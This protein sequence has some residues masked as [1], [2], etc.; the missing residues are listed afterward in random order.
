MIVCIL[1]LGSYWREPND[2]RPVVWNSSGVL[3][4]RGLRQ[5]SKVH[6]HV[7][8]SSR[9]YQEALGSSGLSGS[10]WHVS[11][12]G[13]HLGMR[14]VALERRA[15]HTSSPDWYLVSV[16]EQLVGALDDGSWD[17]ASSHLLSLSSWKTKQEALLLVDRHGWLRGASGSAVLTPGGPDGDWAISR[18]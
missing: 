14:T 9:L 17:P 15:N 8:L 18:W 16:T 4:Q 13:E 12:F 10:C 5:R 7:R 1:S 6:G 11:A 2:G 3:D